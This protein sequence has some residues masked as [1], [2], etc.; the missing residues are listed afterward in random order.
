MF[1]SL[2]DKFNV[3]SVAGLPVAVVRRF[4]GVVRRAAA[5]A[6]EILAEHKERSHHEHIHRL[7][8]ALQE[9]R[10]VWAKRVYS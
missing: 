5:L 8:C 1:V 3:S 6:A 4:E 9:K 2:D 10:L 7:H